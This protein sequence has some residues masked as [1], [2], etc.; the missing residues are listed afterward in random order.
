MKSVFLALIAITSVQL[1][2]SVSLNDTQCIENPTGEVSLTVRG[3]PGPEG[4]RGPKGDIGQTGGI[5][6]KG[7]RGMKGEKGE[8]GDI[9]QVGPKGTKGLQ[10]EPGGSV[11]S[12]E[13]FDRVTNNVQ[14]AL[15]KKV[16]ELNN[17]VLQ[18]VKSRDEGI[19]DAVMRE[20]KVMNETLTL[21]KTTFLHMSLS[22]E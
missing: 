3:V 21:L 9:G 22:V 13:E 16:E 4:P 2:S 15:C 14:T 19:L 8:R 10:G 12:E 11:L 20:L 1:T 17:S 6:L 18:E 5:G 7:I